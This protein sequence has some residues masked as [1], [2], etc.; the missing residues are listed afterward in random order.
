MTDLKYRKKMK[1]MFAEYMI[2]QQKLKTGDNYY[3][4][5]GVNIPTLE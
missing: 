4:M 5:L 1:K 2:S 3:L